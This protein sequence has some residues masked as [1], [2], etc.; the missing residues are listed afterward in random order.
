ECAALI[1][2]PLL[3]ELNLAFGLDFSFFLVSLS[4]VVVASVEFESFLVEVLSP[5]FSLVVSLEYV[6]SVNCDSGSTELDVLVLVVVAVL[7]ICSFSLLDLFV[8]FSSSTRASKASRSF[9]F[10]TYSSFC[11]FNLVISF[12]TSCF[13]SVKSFF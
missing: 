12:S 5:E 9:P 10:V 11:S 1:A 4:A 7:I 6:L 2:L 13:Y 3:P 8:L